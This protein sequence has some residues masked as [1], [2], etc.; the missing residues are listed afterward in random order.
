MFN[1]PGKTIVL[2][3]L[4][5]CVFTEGRILAQATPAPGSPAV[6]QGPSFVPDSTFQGS[7]LAGWHALGQAE[8]TAENG[9]LVG[10]G[11]AGPGWLVLDR[12]YQDT[13]FYAGFRC[14]GVCDTGVLIRATKTE[15]GMKGTFLS[16]KGT[17]LTGESLTLDV[18]GNIADRE[19]LRDAVGMIRF[20][21]PRPDP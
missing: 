3:L 10:K 16:I 6:L 17:Q 13:G 8:W 19:K 9:E 4:A 18:A 15:G 14:V 7:T 12:S 21:P 5:M 1:H 2:C 11:V 20:A